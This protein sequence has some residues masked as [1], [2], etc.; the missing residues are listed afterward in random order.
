MTDMEKPWQGETRRTRDW[1]KGNKA[2]EAIVA[3]WKAADEI[4]G[5]EGRYLKMLLLIGKRKTALAS[6]RWEHITDDWFWDAPAS[7]SKNKRLHAIPLP[8]KATEILH[9][10][11]KEGAVFDGLGGERA[12][13]GLQHNIRTATG[14]EDFFY[15]GV[16]HLLE[17]KLAELKVAPHIRDLLFDHAPNRGSGAGYDH[18]E[19]RDEMFAALNKWA[20]YIDRLLAP[21]ANVTRLR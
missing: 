6:M 1:F 2:D 10:R 15:H 20:G 13:R 14:I 9:P 4:S 3:L 8:K 19:Y 12:L 21:A 16:R 11:R 5:N 7:G 17:S 18:Y